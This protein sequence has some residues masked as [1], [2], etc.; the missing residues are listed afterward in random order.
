MKHTHTR[1]LSLMLHV[2][3]WFKTKQSVLGACRR[4]W[5]G[6]F[7]QVFTE[8]HSNILRSIYAALKTGTILPKV[9]ALREY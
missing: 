3:G 4:I 6:L 9:T 8:S 7:K 5:T 2:I 1:A